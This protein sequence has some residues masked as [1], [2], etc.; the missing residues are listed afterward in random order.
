MWIHLDAS[1]LS[2]P[3]ARSRDDDFFFLNKK[4]NLPIDPSQPYPPNNGTILVLYKII[5]T[6]MPFAQEA[7]TGAVFINTRKFVPILQTLEELGHQQ[8]P[9]PVQLD[10]KTAVRIFTDTMVQRQSK[11]MDMISYWLKCRKIQDQLHLY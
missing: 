9:N 7:E 10:N 11:P 3:K 5:D 1:Y 8:G 6:I 2:K 4:P